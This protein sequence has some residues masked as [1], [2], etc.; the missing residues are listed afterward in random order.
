MLGHRDRLEPTYS[1]HGNAL[2]MIICVSLG[3]HFSADRLSLGCPKSDW[4]Y[5]T[6]GLT[7]SLFLH[8][9]DVD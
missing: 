8:R 9:S 5:N 3:W 6:I 7:V 4:M 2:L 1:R